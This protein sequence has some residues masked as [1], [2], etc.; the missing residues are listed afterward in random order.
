MKSQLLA[1]RKIVKKNLT[2]TKKLVNCYTTKRTSNQ[3]GATMKALL[4]L[5]NDTRTCIA[6]LHN[7]NINGFKKGQHL[8]KLNARLRKLCSRIVELAIKHPA[9]T[10]ISYTDALNWL[11]TDDYSSEFV[12]TCAVYATSAI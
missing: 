2:K 11:I 8:A 4:A 9:M 10:G 7:S 3:Q 12:V 5:T 1:K 6:A